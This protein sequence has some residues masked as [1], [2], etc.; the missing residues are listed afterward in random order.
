MNT[1]DSPIEKPLM[2]LLLEN[3]A[4]E[5]LPAARCNPLLARLQARIGDD[6]AAPQQVKSVTADVGEWQPFTPGV[7]VKLLHRS[8]EFQSYLL[9]LEPGSMLPPHRHPLIEECVVL[10]GSLRVRSTQGE[11]LATPGTFHLAPAGEKHA[12]IRSDEGALIY[13]R[14]AV[15]DKDD[16]DWLAGGALGAAA[17]GLRHWFRR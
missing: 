7:K 12:A 5:T 8:D 10:E 11:I 17:Q 9:R 4:E 15:P 16:I 3:I 1:P 2:H 6:K 13:L 14:G